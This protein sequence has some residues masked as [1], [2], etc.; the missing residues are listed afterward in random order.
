MVMGDVNGR[1][2]D[3]GAQPRLMVVV[4]PGR[5]CV[6]QLQQNDEIIVIRGTLM[7]TDIPMTSTGDGGVGVC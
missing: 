3:R 6:K 5:S 4:M 1:V 2:E 7:C